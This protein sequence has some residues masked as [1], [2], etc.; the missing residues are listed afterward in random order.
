MSLAPL[1]VDHLNLFNQLE[2]LPKSGELLG[3]ELL[4]FCF[5]QRSLL[6]LTRFLD[7]DRPGPRGSP[8]RP[9]SSWRRAPPSPP[10]GRP[11][12]SG[13]ASRSLGKTWTGFSVDWAVLVSGRNAV[14]VLSAPCPCIDA[15]V[16]GY[17]PASEHPEA[18]R[19]CPLV[20]LMTVDEVLP[21]QR[22]RRLTT[23]RA[24]Y[25]DRKDTGIERTPR[26]T[27]ES[28]QSSCALPSARSGSAASSAGTAIC[29]SSRAS[30][31]PTQ[32]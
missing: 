29:A 18:C 16:A 3:I 32:K 20:L 10:C 21:T 31:A 15:N 11:S 1:S 19:C 28:S 5:E 17:G 8:S 26:K 24:R 27:S 2:N 6:S 13:R 14:S 30:G 7:W 25:E 12:L 9:S 23:G 4:R 22:A